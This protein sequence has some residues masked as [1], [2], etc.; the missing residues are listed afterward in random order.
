M[1]FPER[2]PDRACFPRPREDAEVDINP[3]GFCWWRAENAASYRFVL[4]D[5]NGRLLHEAP[6]LID[7]VHVPDRT[8]PAGPYKWRVQALAEDGRV[9]DTWGPR[10]FRIKRGAPEQPWVAPEALLARVPQEHPRLVFL[11]RDLP[12]LRAGL[13]DGRRACLERLVARADQCLEIPCPKEPRYDRLKRPRLR[14]M[15]YKNAFLEFRK[16]ADWG[17]EPLALAYLFTG[18]T[19]FGQ[20]ALRIL[21]TVA[22][23]DAE[24]ISSILA[25]YGDELGL[26]LVKTAAH[27]YD[28]LYDLMGPDQ[29]TLVRNMLIARADQMVR[30]LKERHDFLAFPGD[31][32]AGRLPGYLC[33]HAIAL[34]DDPRAAGWL[35]Y[36]LRAIMTGFPHWGGSDGG[37]AQGI[38]YGTAY[39]RIMTP[40]FD[41]LRAATGLDIYQRP[42]FRKIGRF[43]LY[44]ASPIGE[45]KPFG[46]GG[47]QGGFGGLASLM[48][49]HAQL[50]GEP[51]YEWWAAR[52]GHKGRGVSGLIELAFPAHVQARPP[53]DKAPD[54]TFRGVGWAALHSDLAEPSRDTFILFKS[55]PYASVSHSHADQNTFC[56]L[57]G[58]KALAMPSGYYGPAYGMPHHAE[59]TRQTKAHCG[60]LVNNHGQPWRDQGAQGHIVAF[61]SEGPFGYVCGDASAAYAGRLTKFLRHVLLVRPGL[62]CILDEFAA[63]KP[64]SF[65][66]LLHGMEPLCTDEAAQTVVSHRDGAR[67]TLHLATRGGLV[68]SQTDRFDTPY[69]AGN[70]K[71]FARDMPNHHHFKASTRTRRKTRRI[72]A[73]AVI[74]G[75]GE[76]FETVLEEPAPGWIRLRAMFSDGVARLDA[77]SAG[78]AEPL[79]ALPA[80]AEIAAAWT[81]NTGVRQTMLIAPAG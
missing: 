15:S 1:S 13:D 80:N 61:R 52:A 33:E 6:G 10:A 5:T 14:K 29:E 20:A 68:F 76:Q 43:F 17:M 65:Q 75:P 31:S 22:Q 59:W 30:R 79:D 34:A 51:A 26:S 54:A 48:A 74:E 77:R 18:D 44:C 53:A 40:P 71:K 12:A 78:R 38:G 39:N 57:K 35:D 56:V 16:V 24:G 70:P 21:T 37:W 60:V 4:E 28:W 25:P 19:R 32:H 66:W 2:R 41:A 47:S 7:P 23:W 42:F 36:A 67:M 72:V 69:N 49:H 9:L 11:E 45:I 50:F 62:L 27:C 8:F 64:A 63:P 55:S 58:G 46:D 81:P 3:P 73:L